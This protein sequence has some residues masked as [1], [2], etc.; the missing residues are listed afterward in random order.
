M[1][2]AISA[3]F[4]TALH[5]TSVPAESPEQLIYSL[6]E[7]IVQASEKVSPTVVNIR[8]VRFTQDF[9]F[10]IIPQEGLGS[11]IIFD[12]EGYILTNEHV[13]RGAREIRVVL[14]DG[15]EFEGKL[16][17]SDARVDLAVLKIEAKDI[18]V[19]K[20]GDSDKLRAGEFCIAIGNPFGLQNTITFGVISA[21]GRHIQ[22]S[23]GKI[24]ED[25]IQ[26]DAPINPGNSGGPLINIK[27]EVIGIN[28]AIIPYAQ[29]IGFAIPVNVARDIIDE[30]IEYGRVIRPWIG[31]YYYS[32]TSQVK[33]RFKLTVDSGIY[34]AQVA[35]Q[36]PADKAKIKEGDVIVKIDDYAIKSAEDVREMLKNAK[37][38][39]KVNLLLVRQGEYKETIV[40][41]GEMPAER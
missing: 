38:G 40:E 27:G 31:I 11:G 16:I 34:I 18:P 20:L 37:V 26:T 12:N 7:S 29:G 2:V 28:T 15:R 23:P 9:F 13:V 25:L 8:T 36:S 21:K 32:V 19:A 5:V 24:L 22:A 6:Q 1:V 35:P 30:L 39:Q 33:E 4:V 17:G 10:N 14:P 3:L 41:L